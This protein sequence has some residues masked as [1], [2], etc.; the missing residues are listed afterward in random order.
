[1]SFFGTLV[2]LASSINVFFFLLPLGYSIFSSLLI[3]PILRAGFSL[4][5]TV[6]FVLKPDSSLHPFDKFF[7]DFLTTFRLL[8]DSP[9]P[10][11]FNNR[12][13]GN[14]FLVY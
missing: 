5:G 2:G 12:S 1:L 8:Y 3:R 10:H 6:F 13:L 9:P 7:L 4:T 11:A 14:F